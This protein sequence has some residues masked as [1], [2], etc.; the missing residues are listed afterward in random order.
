M[1]LYTIRY[2]SYFK[3]GVTKHQH[4]RL[5]SYRLHNPE[6]QSFDRIWETAL[7]VSVEKHIIN[8]FAQHSV[9]QTE[10]FHGADAVYHM[11]LM[12][13]D[14]VL[15]GQVE[16][17][18]V[19]P[20]SVF[21]SP[22][23]VVAYNKTSG[24]MVSQYPSLSRASKSL[25]LDVKKIQA[26][27]EGRGKFSGDYIFR[28]AGGEPPNSDDILRA[29]T[30][31]GR[32]VVAIDPSTSQELRIYPTS[33]ATADDGYLPAKVNECARRNA[34]LHKG[35][36]WRFLEERSDVYLPR[37]TLERAIKQHRRYNGRIGN[38]HHVE[39]R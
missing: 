25:G 28:Y 14:K 20:S 6:V 10:W 38:H 16:V 7:A 5:K 32:P 11:V 21:K 30:S 17:V 19:P 15:S 23:A 31:R 13:I 3:I 9:R 24:V 34:V 26:C 12:E 33:L 4:S 22:R 35:V 18:T 1:Y 37:A 39:I 8:S 36:L 27:C 29:T 2:G